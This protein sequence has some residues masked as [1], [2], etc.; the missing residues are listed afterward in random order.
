MTRQK[1]PSS[2]VRAIEGGASF[3]SRQEESYCSAANNS[4][5][6]TDAIDRLNRH[7]LHQLHLRTRSKQQAMAEYTP[8]EKLFERLRDK[9]IVLTGRASGIGAATVRLLDEHKAHVVFGDVNASAA[10]DNV[11]QHSSTATFVQCDVTKYEEFYRL[12]KTAYAKHGRID[13]AISCAGIFE[14]GNCF[15]PGLTV[16]SVGEDPGNTQTMDVNVM[17]TLHC[18]R[19]AAVF[20]RE[21]IQKGGNKSLVL[22]SSVNA[23]RES[24]GLFL[25]YQIYKHAIHGLLRSSRKTLFE[26]DGI[27]V[28]AVCPGVTN[29]PMAAHVARPFREQGLSVPKPEQVAKII[30]GLEVDESI[31]DKAF[32]IEGGGA[33]EFEDGFVR[34]QPRWLGEKPTRRMRVNSEAVQKGALVPK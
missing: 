6:T 34:E 33:W 9:V 16:D 30:V 17:G 21:T 18:S 19:I 29:I 3:R 7:P 28:N 20:P 22:L 32:Y 27:R 8:D 14:Q 12:F 24:P 31:Q 10:Y 11:V 13:H 26:R 1:R 5:L 2:A 23:F 4:I 15:D 25:L